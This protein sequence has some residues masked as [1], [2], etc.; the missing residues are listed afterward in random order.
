M[1]EDLDSAFLRNNEQWVKAYELVDWSDI[2]SIDKLVGCTEALV[3]KYNNPNKDV[4]SSI[5]AVFDELL[6]RYPLFYGYWKRYVSVKYQLDGLDASISILDASLEAFPT[7]IDLWMDKINVCLA[8]NHEETQFIRLQFK[9]CEKLLGNHFL[10]HDVWDKHIEF[11]TK[12]QNWPEV[13]EL[14][15]K[16]V[17]LPLH[18]YA[19]YYTNFKEF[20]EYH[21]EFAGKSS[22]QDVDTTFVHT[23]ELVN[24]IW[25]Y[26]SQIKQPFFNIPALTENELKNWD[27][28]LVFLLREPKVS[29]DFILCTFE[30]CL[31]PCYRYEIFWDAAISFNNDK[32]GFER[33]LGTYQR[34]ADALPDDNKAFRLKYINFLEDNLNSGTKY[35][36]KFYMDA[37][38]SFQL[39][40]THDSNPMVKYIRFYKKMHF[41]SS[42]DDNDQKILEKESSYAKFLDKTVK[43]Y[44]EKKSERG[45][46]QLL[47][48]INSLNISILIVEL[49]KCSWLVLKNLVQCRKYFIYFSKFPEMKNSAPFWLLFY[50]FEKSQ[51]NV[52]KVSKFVDQLGKDIFLPT[53]IVNEILIDYRNFYLSNKTCFE[54][55]E[56]LSQNRLGYDPIIHA[57]LKI[58][59]PTWQP[60]FKP[61]KDWFRTDEYKS[62]GHPGIFIEKPKIT[63]A[64]L[65]NFSMR[66]QTPAPLPSFRNLEKLN[67][68]PKV[69][70][71]MSTEYITNS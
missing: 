11:E 2:S 4:K 42:L 15:K 31:V 67:Q 55:E 44:L 63:N 16:I 18:Q 3:Q 33:A 68:K 24:K 13:Y 35:I 65:E 7:S 71:Y 30:R 70:D 37:L 66:Q 52:T 53:A 8:N 57:R 21:Q 40:W 1:F 39:K 54:Y 64:V 61:G 41:S 9:K 20:L 48:M 58:N 27:D 51:K 69:E 56:N 46:S 22:S 47:T 36:A 32:F 10:S 49:I 50:K 59:N 29:N 43:T 6:T 26:E 38:C 25:V 45:S 34:A 62:N 17:K 5:Y 19:K 12:Q 23:Q 14:Y 60:N 28:Y